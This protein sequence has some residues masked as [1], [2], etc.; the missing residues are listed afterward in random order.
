MTSSSNVKLAAKFF[1]W[2]MF[3]YMSYQVRASNEKLSNLYKISIRSTS[4]SNLSLDRAIA[5]VVCNVNKDAG[6][7]CVSSNFHYARG[8]TP[9]CVTSGGAHFCVLALGQHSFKLRRTVATVAS[10]WRR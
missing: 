6:I 5:R 7:K 8:I 10:R 1:G 3:F 2:F 9:K 4:A